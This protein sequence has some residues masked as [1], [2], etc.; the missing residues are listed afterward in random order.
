MVRVTYA[1]RP[2]QVRHRVPGRP[3]SFGVQTSKV[4]AEFGKATQHDAGTLKVFNTSTLRTDLR[5]PV[6][7]APSHFP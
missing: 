4:C 2:R 6:G 3:R 7:P 1:G 5:P